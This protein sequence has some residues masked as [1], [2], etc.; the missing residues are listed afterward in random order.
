MPRKI[1]PEP[2]IEQGDKEKLGLQPPKPP[3]KP[4]AKPA[5]PNKK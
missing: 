4:P 1:R 3:A 2:L 5:K